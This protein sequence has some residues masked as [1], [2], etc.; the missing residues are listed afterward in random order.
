MGSLYYP[1]PWAVTVRFVQLAA[2]RL[3]SDVIVSLEEAFG[4][5]IIGSVAG[6]V[7]GT[8]IGRSRVVALSLKPLLNFLRHI[9]PLAW[10]PLAILWFGVGY[11]SKTSV[12]V[13]I[14]F[15]NLVVNTAHGVSSVDETILKATRVLGLRQGQR[16]MVFLMSALPDVLV[17][18]RFALGLSWGGVVIAELVAGNSGI[19][20][21]EFYGG[22]SFDVAQIMVGMLALAIVGILTNWLFLVAQGRLFPWMVSNRLDLNTTARATE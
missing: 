1:G 11:W 5:W 20:A 8:A 19:G 12:I 22:Q 2:G 14:A 18:L 7:V 21:L 6:I 13:L 15:F 10:V 4:G 16:V 3:P 9:S 17:G